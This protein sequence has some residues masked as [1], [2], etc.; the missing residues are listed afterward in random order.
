MIIEI[1]PAALSGNIHAPFSK[2]DAHRILIAAAL[3]AEPTTLTLSCDSEDIRATVRCLEA[4]GAKLIPLESSYRMEPIWNADISPHP[5]LDC[6]ESGTTLRLLLPIVAALGVDAEFIA[7][8]RLPE[9]PLSE[10]TALLN[11]NGCTF[12]ADKPPFK[13]SGRLNPGVYSLPG[14]VSSQ[15]ISGLLFALPLLDGDSRVILTTKLESASYV[16]MTRQ[17]LVH[18]GVS[19]HCDSSNGNNIFFIKGNQ[20]YIS[21]GSAAVEGDWSNAAFFLTAGALNHESITINGLS[22]SSLQGD[23]AICELLQRFGADVTTDGT[24]RVTVCAGSH[25]RSRNAAINCFSSAI[26]CALSNNCSPTCDCSPVNNSPAETDHFTVAGCFST[27]IGE[28]CADELRADGFQ[29]PS[30]RAAEIDVSAV[31]DLFP[32]LAVVASVARGTTRLYN[33]SRLRMKESDRLRSVA[34]M[35]RGLGADVCELEDELVI[36]GKPFLT[37]GTVSGENDHRIVMA[38]ATAS[39]VCKNPVTI[40]GAEAINKSYPNFF[41]DF[42][43]LGGNA[44]V[45]NNGQAN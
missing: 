1:N 34:V 45:I 22:A 8:G 18:F 30:L 9:R 12:S 19:S 37:G 6:G 43:A 2:S 33:A 17:T 23:R 5:K 35:L 20:R 26:D 32:V 21:L 44:Y 29:A 14:D 28:L 3:S 42:N 11:A 13:L 38:A 31:P 10:L 7:H 16:E 40:I 41:S 39:T 24:G 36:N 27:G 25:I 4:L 15:Y